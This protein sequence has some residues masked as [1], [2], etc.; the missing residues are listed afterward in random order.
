MNM[1]EKLLEKHTSSEILEILASVEK[2]DKSTADFK[3]FGYIPIFLVGLFGNIIIIV[4]FIKINKNRIKKMSTYHFLI[5]L[6]AITDLSATIAGCI[7]SISLNTFNK[8]TINNRETFSYWLGIIKGGFIS[9]SCWMLPLLYYDRYRSIVHP[10]KRK[11]KKRLA[12]YVWICILVVRILI[13]VVF[14]F[15]I[16]KNDKMSL[17]HAIEELILSMVEVCI[18]FLP[19]IPLVFFYWRIS[20]Y[21][22]R[23]NINKAS[24]ATAST[25]NEIQSG[26]DTNTIASKTIR[27]LVILYV[28]LVW[29]GR[30]LNFVLFFQTLHDIMFPL[31]NYLLLFVLHQIGY[32]LIFLN[33]LV[34]MFVYAVMIKD[35]RSFLWRLVPCGKK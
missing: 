19:L 16:E 26:R 29:P 5:I 14:K 34:N 9:S 13:S 10:F 1:N 8:N 21:L 31:E 35:F 12:F 17:D 32:V 23:N 27:N 25:S 6:L 18:D 2:V 4:Y 3:T 30:I 11:L 15:V 7:Y 24:S 33:S 20:R 22:A 28:F